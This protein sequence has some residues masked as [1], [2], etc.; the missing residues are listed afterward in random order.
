MTPQWCKYQASCQAT[1]S[2]GVKDFLAGIDADDRV[3]GKWGGELSILTLEELLLFETIKG[4]SFVAGRV[5]DKGDTG[6]GENSKE[7]RFLLFNPRVRA[8]V[9]QILLDQ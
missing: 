3:D 4:Y 5:Q 8:I 7:S 2:I 9:I 6:I 1:D